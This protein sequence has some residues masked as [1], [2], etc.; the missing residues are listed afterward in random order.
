MQT[1]NEKIDGKKYIPNIRPINVLLV[2]DEDSHREL[3]KE[4]IGMQK[5]K[6]NLAMVSEGDEALNYLTKKGEYTDAIRPDLILL[7]LYMPN[8]SGFEVLEEIKKN[9]DIE[10]IPVFILT[11]SSANED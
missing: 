11:S 1:K 2:E 10:N 3:A 6:I 9:G 8:K 5:I 4:I 7:D